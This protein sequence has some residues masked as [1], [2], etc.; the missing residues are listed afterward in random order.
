VQIDSTGTVIDIVL[1]D[2]A[3]PIQ[4]PIT[5]TL[6]ESDTAQLRDT[7]DGEKFTPGPPAEDA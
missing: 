2:G 4:P 1:W 7:W 5:D 3:E 6:I